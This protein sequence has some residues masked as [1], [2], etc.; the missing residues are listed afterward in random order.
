[1]MRYI[2]ILLLLA[3][4]LGFAAEVRKQSV[5]IPSLSND[6]NGCF[7]DQTLAGAGALT[8]NGALVSGGVCVMA[9]A[10]KI[11]I[12]GTGNN[13]ADTATIVGR[14][15]DNLP[16]TEDLVL[17][18]NGTVAS[19]LYYLK[20]ESITVGSALTG[21]IEGGPLST[22]GAVSV[23]IVPDVQSL[24]SA[25]PVEIEITGTGTYAVE[26]T[27]DNA[28]STASACS[29]CTAPDWN[30]HEVLTAKTAT[31][32]SNVVIP[33]AGLR[34]KATAYTSGT[35]ELTILQGVQ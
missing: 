17:A 2:A 8:L 20:I 18:N 6:A 33:V 13:S 32:V 29:T 16:Q 30:T 10:Q 7:A 5:T 35:G 25:Y 15:A 9:A 1:M 14:D 23:V 22:N 19:A 11:S 24:Y 26:Y 28:P 12:E 27:L 3:A 4:Q 21:N 31:T 34:L